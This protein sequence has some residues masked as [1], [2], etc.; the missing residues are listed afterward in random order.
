[1][2]GGWRDAGPAG[3]QD[4]LA[5]T[6]AC[7]RPGHDRH[8][9]I[10]SGPGWLQNRRGDNKMPYRSRHEPELDTLWSLS[11]RFAFQ[12]EAARAPRDSRKKCCP[13]C[14]G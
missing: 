3:I 1:M 13:A 10:M 6:F 9:L 2:I 7:V 14:F 12:S 8:G 4:R 5:A 11:D